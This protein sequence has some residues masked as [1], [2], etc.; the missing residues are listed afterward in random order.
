MTAPAALAAA[1]R[2]SGQHG[3]HASKPPLAPEGLFNTRLARVCGV[4]TKKALTAAAVTWL[5]SRVCVQWRLS[6]LGHAASLSAT[7]VT[8]DTW[9]DILCDDAF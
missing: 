8:G 9:S 2:S 3:E 7:A 5:R 4:T 6:D 1:L